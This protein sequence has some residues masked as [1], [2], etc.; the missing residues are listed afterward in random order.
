MKRK[1]LAVL[2]TAS[3]LLAG[4]GGGGDAPANQ[5]ASAGEPEQLFKQNCASCHGVDLKGSSGPDL[6]RV[7][8]EHDA[9]EIESI[10]INGKGN[11][12]PGILEGEEAKKVAEWLA[13]KK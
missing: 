3:A 2:F 6:T 11:M 13:E 8:A 5:G 9:A 10:I 7:G 4:C 1:A 12:P